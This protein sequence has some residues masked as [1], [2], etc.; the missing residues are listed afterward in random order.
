MLAI[1]NCLGR[2]FGRFDP[3]KWRIYFDK[4]KR[5]HSP[6]WNVEVTF[7]VGRMTRGKEVIAE[8]KQ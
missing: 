3:G 5:P 6:A 4:K 2:F 1:I 7:S 8:R